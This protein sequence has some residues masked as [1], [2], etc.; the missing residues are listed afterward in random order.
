MIDKSNNLS[1]IV[2]IVIIP[3]CLHPIGAQHSDFFAESG[4]IVKNTSRYTIEKHERKLN[5]I[6]LTLN[7]AGP[8]PTYSVRGGGQI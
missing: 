4:A 3:M 8:N 6:F 7:R 1:F 2:Y 5:P